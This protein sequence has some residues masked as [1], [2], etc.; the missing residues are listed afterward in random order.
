MIFFFKQ[1]T[2]YEIYQCDWSSDVCSSDLL[3]DY[4]WVFLLN[5][6]DRLRELASGNSQP[7]LNAQMIKN[8][9]VIIPP[10]RIQ[11]KI[12]DMVSGIKLQIKDLK[13]Q[14]EQ[15]QITAIKEFELEIFT[16]A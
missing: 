3:T 2:A 13:N 1:K 9:P 5:E 14:A 6:Y 11:K 16:T 8:Y 12:I 10:V 4:L 7:N 15:N